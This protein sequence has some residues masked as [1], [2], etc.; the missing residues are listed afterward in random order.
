MSQSTTTSH[1]A[2]YFP[3]KGA[4]LVLGTAETL[5]IKDGY[6]KIAVDYAS[7]SPLEVWRG[8]FG[9]VSLPFL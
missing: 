4:K 3:S 5:P 9:L 6:V 7:P 2:I 1:K 8:H